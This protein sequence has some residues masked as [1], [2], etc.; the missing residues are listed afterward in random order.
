[1]FRTAHEDQRSSLRVI[2]VRT[3]FRWRATAA[4]R[5]APSGLVSL[6]RSCRS[7]TKTRLL[8]RSAVS[9]CRPKC[10]VTPK[11][12]R[13]DTSVSVSPGVLTSSASES[14]WSRM[15]RV[16]VAMN[17]SVPRFT[18]TAYC[19]RPWPVL[20]VPGR[21]E[22]PKPPKLTRTRR[23][24]WEWMP[25]RSAADHACPVRIGVRQCTLPPQ[26]VANSEQTAHGTRRTRRD[27]CRVRC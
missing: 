27:A 19:L 23:P 16:R 14:S 6:R 2:M 7:S 26:P 24:R 5:S 20:Q 15:A 13:T 9:S 21:P 22:G 12:P 10:V 25:H 3:S 4:A 17:R 18:A 11:C 8:S 1:M